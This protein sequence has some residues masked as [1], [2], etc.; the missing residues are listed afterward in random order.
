MGIPLRPLPAKLIIGLIAKDT[1]RLEHTRGLLEKRFGRVD[2]TSPVFAFDQTH[3]YEGEFGQNLQR[4]FLC[5]EKLI[6]ADTLAAIKLWTNTLEI[7]LSDG[8]KRRTVNIDPGYISLAKLVLATTKNHSHRIYDRRGIFE[9]VT[10]V[11][12]GHTFAPL[13][14]TY[15]D[16]RQKSHIEFFNKARE[17]Y[18]QRIEK[19]YGVSQLYRCV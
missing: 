18:K 4:M 11:F 15:P 12:R 17:A 7:K 10:L 19:I 3:Y 6:T 2:M 16:Y 8:I 9:E 13:D 1:K 5:F 14:W